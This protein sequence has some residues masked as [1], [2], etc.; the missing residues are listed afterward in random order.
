MAKTLLS[1]A[2]PK[3]A[4][5]FA[6][7]IPELLKIF[8]RCRRLSKSSYFFLSYPAPVTPGGGK[9]SAVCARNLS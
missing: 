7:S 6:K 8:L 2:E 1:P 5:Y 4:M 3:Q 9:K